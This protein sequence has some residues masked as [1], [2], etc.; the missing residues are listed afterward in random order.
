MQRNGRVL[1]RYGLCT[2]YLYFFHHSS[3]KSS[4]SGIARHAL[5]IGWNFIR[6]PGVRIP[7][8]RRTGKLYAFVKGD[9]IFSATRYVSRL[10]ARGTGG[11]Q[12]QG[13]AYSSCA[14][15]EDWLCRIASK[16]SP[17]Q[18]SLNPL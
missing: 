10:E 16:G 2:T 12:K 5:D 15:R 18:F 7:V 9:K 4:V 8:E 17:L 1:G 13:A 14:S 11:N 6:M 3:L